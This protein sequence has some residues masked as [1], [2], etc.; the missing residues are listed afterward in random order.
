MAEHT[1]AKRRPS[2][3]VDPVGQEAEL[4]PE[5]LEAP[6]RSAMRAKI[7]SFRELNKP[8]WDSY[9][10][11]PISAKTI[12]FALAVLDSGVLPVGGSVSPGSDGSIT[13]EG[14]AGEWSLEVLF[15]TVELNIRTRNVV[16]LPPSGKR[17]S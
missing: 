15:E 3:A 14:N 7:E 12:A 11:T 2:T 13:F 5:I 1:G 10:A 4:M 8:G 9:E 16:R 17:P 6:A